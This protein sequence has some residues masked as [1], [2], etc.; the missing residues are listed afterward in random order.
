MTLIRVIDCETTGM[1]DDSKVVEI[2]CLDLDADR[3][4]IA[5]E[6]QHFINP[7][8]PIPPQASAIHHITDAMVASAPLF[9]EVHADYMDAD[10][11]VAHN[12]RF[13]QRYLG[14]FGKPW[15]DTYRCALVAWPDAPAHSNQV[16]RYWLGLESPP[17]SAG[18]AHRALYD[19][20]VT[21]MLFR[22]LADEMTLEK[23]L[24]AS[25]SPA[26]LTK[27]NFGKHRG[28]RFSELP[29]GYLEW[30]SGQTF[31]EDVMFT[32]KNELE[33]RAKA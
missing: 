23:M 24:E 8:I 16:L 30:M 7:Q 21:A 9:G 33:R 17:E 31:D 22:R 6:K 26:L 12:S 15:I 19:C 32:V 25:Q 5:G 4:V 27:I 29:I 28:E 14:N 1:E 18:H 3:E 11:Y 13:D 10:Y 20:Y 2:A